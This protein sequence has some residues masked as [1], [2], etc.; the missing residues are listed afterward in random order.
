VARSSIW[1]SIYNV[2]FHSAL[3]LG[4]ELLV[5]E[6]PQYQK[7]PEDVFWPETTFP[8]DHPASIPPKPIRRLPIK[9]LPSLE[10]HKT[11]NRSKQQ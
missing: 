2:R 5:Q 4:L 10:I 8:P 7:I 6:Y 1:P 9:V 3:A 11:L